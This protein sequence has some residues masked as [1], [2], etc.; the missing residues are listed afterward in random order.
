MK[1]LGLLNTSFGLILAYS[2]TA[3]P[4]CV[5]MLK[6]FFDT[7]PRELEEAADG[8]VLANPSLLEDRPALRCPRSR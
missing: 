5:W 6:G 3:L 2:V 4:L 8:R 7:V 1:A